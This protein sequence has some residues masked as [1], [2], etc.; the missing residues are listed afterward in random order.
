MVDVEC[1]HTFGIGMTVFNIFRRER[2][3]TKEEQDMACFVYLMFVSTISFPANAFLCISF[4][5]VLIGENR[6]VLFYCTAI[7]FGDASNRA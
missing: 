4:C 7:Y 2:T 1:G 3:L 6:I 5:L